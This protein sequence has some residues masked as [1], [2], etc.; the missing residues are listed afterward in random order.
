MRVMLV[1][2][3]LP[4]MQ[5]GVGDYTLKLAEALAVLPGL[6]VA[7]LTSRPAQPMATSGHATIL[8]SVDSWRFRSLPSILR[9]LRS[10]R[11]DLVHIQYP[12]Q[13]YGGG[14]FPIALPAILRLAGF[15]VT[16]TWHEARQHVTL[17][18][19]FWLLIQVVASGGLVVVRP[20]YRS[21]MP[22]L[23]RFALLNK[24]QR[25][26][27]NASV[28]VPTQLTAAEK[29]EIHRKF[30]GS[31]RSLV[32]YFGFIYPSKGIE[33]LFEI[34][35]PEIHQLVIIGAPVPGQSD[36]Y[37]ASIRSAI[38]SPPWAGRSTMTGFLPS[39]EVT[40]IL[41]AASAVV[42]PFTAGG[43]EWNTSIHGAQ[44]Q[45]VFVLTTSIERHGYDVETNT[46][47]ARPGDVAEMR[48]ALK[49]YL[50]QKNPVLGKT[51]APTWNFIAAEHT[52]LYRALILGR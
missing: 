23:L 39:E 19:M 5:C 45:G 49:Q 50:G 15:R 2:G 13:G 24:N 4:P 40:R 43:G 47:F 9:I 14:S 8:A 51:S 26:V 16:Q 12:T 18:G 28:L 48:N 11:P 33:L 31:R 17:G 46:Y 22:R 10:W 32:V 1:S 29:D 38:E 20:R 41:A 3:S 30:G 6:E 34:A 52:E 25:F 35:S 7:V 37:T 44:A 21:L 42:L 36:R 27:P